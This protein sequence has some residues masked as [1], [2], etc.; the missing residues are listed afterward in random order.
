[1]TVE[2]LIVEF[3]FDAKDAI[4]TMDKVQNRLKSFEQ[5]AKDISISADTSKLQNGLLKIV[6]VAGKTS[7][8]LESIGKS[9]VS[10]I[11]KAIK[12]S[13]NLSSSLLKVGA[14]A[15]AGAVVGSGAIASKTSEEATQARAFG[16]DLNSIKAI[17]KGLKDVSL[18]SVIDQFEEMRNKVQLSIT[19]LERDLKSGKASIKEFNLSG[20]MDDKGKKKDAKKIEEGTLNDLF[21]TTLGNGDLGK[22]D[23]DFKGIMNTAKA[24]QVFSKK[25]ANE[26]FNIMA[27]LVDVSENYISSMDDW[28]GGDAQKIFSQ[29][30]MEAQKTNQS[31]E[32]LL[33]KR[34]DSFFID[35]NDVDDLI[36]YDKS[37]K[38]LGSSISQVTTKASAGLGSVLAPYIEQVNNY[39]QNNKQQINEFID[40]AS[41]KLQAFFE[42]VKAFGAEK[43]FKDDQFV[44]FESAITI[45]IDLVKSKLSE[46][47]E[48]F[49]NALVN[50]PFGQ[51]LVEVSGYIEKFAMVIAGAVVLNAIATLVTTL[52][53]LGTAFG[54]VGGA[55]GAISAP[56]AV[57][58]AAIV[59]LVALF[60]N[61]ESVTAWAD[62]VKS[63]ISEA[64]DSIANRVSSAVDSI[65]SKLAELWASL[66]NSSIGKGISD[67]WDKT[68]KAF[69]S[70]D[71][72]GSSSEP[73]TTTPIAST[74][75]TT[76]PTT[77]PTFNPPTLPTN[78]VTTSNQT[79]NIN[80]NTSNNITVNVSKT[81]ASPNDIASEVGRVLETDAMKRNT[82]VLSKV[83]NKG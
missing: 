75:S 19:S 44:G 20:Y 8:A 21:T 39:I 51:K 32:Q 59:G 12:L 43:F 25:I 3:G 35:K 10:S 31:I 81:N 56:V 27:K 15:V 36:A 70:G 30:R 49:S 61:W 63:A 28:L 48:S 7:R 68:K 64:M 23:A 9:A 83:P 54:V 17:Q 6:A 22:V 57:A 82:T 18:K 1:M 45:A 78:A 24:L 37:I 72:K 41:S 4:S 47:S 53:T 65:K 52:G 50:N 55:I 14:G 46:L 58:V 79:N 16:T 74:A 5:Q 38:D 13:A 76:T 60:A 26:Q 29:L 62:G 73:T 67:A 66:K 71:S 42:K 11:S 2:E 69:G 34:K 77:T 40:F 33:A 80:S